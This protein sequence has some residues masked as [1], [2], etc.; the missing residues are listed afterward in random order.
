MSGKR[1]L[2]TDEEARIEV[3]T[4]ERINARQEIFYDLVMERRRQ[5]Q[6]HGHGALGLVDS[7]KKR[8]RKLTI[9]T[10]E[11]GEVARAIHDG[12]DKNLRDEL[13]QVAA[14]AIAWL[15]AIDIDPKKSQ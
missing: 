14:V 1:D 2:H 3:H 7:R 6:L 11:V 12:D 9:L 13:V 10:E 8:D 4:V 15:E 5:Y